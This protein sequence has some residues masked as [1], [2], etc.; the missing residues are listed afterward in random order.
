[1]TKEYCDRKVEQLTN[2][3]IE[4]YNSQDEQEGRSIIFQALLSSSLRVSKRWA[5]EEIILQDKVIFWRVI[6]GILVVLC[7]LLAMVAT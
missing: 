2:D 5:E 6:S 3:M 1:M 7:A 4:A